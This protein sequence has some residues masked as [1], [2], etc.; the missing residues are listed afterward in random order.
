ME[1]YADQTVSSVLFL[2]LESCGVRN[3][4]A[5]HAASHL[6]K[7]QGIVNLLRL[8]VFNFNFLEYIFFQFFRTVPLAKKLHIMPLPKEILAKHKVSEEE[9]YRGI[10]SERLCECTFEVASRAHQHLVKAR[11]L[12]R[13]V[14]EEGRAAL[15]PA[16]SVDVYLQRLQEVNHDVLNPK[17]QQRHWKLLPKLWITNF[18]NKY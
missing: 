7:A 6:G 2:V 13:K 11:S 10:P 18:K 14:P 17:L 5:D 1:K 15:L 9:V 3:V 8:M 12:M 4:N 16:V